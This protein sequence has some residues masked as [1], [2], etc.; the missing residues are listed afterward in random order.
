VR[1]IRKNKSVKPQQHKALATTYLQEPL[2]RKMVAKRSTTPERDEKPKKKVKK[3][4][5]P[6]SGI[7]DLQSVEEFR[8]FL[9]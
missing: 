1:D 3:S 7:N 8:H 4:H 5:F 9:L 6:S 2:Q